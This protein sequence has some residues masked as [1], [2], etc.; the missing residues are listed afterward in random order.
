MPM[1]LV[2]STEAYSHFRCGKLMLK[3][4]CFQPESLKESCVPKGYWKLKAAQSALV[5]AKQAKAADLKR[6]VCA[7]VKV[8][9]NDLG[10]RRDRHV[11]AVP[12][13]RD[14]QHSTGASDRFASPAHMIQI[15]LTPSIQPHVNTDLNSAM[16]RKIMKSAA[17][18]DRTAPVKEAC[19]PS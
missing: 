9:K 1:K 18:P 14:R 4:T 15:T 13:G 17:H 2:A 3:L 5:R 12:G 6:V 11:G 7:R 8:I 10:F 16:T 19:A